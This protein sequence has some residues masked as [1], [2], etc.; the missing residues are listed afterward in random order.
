MCVSLG[1]KI[2]REYT[3]MLVIIFYSNPCHHTIVTGPP[4][5]HNGVKYGIWVIQKLNFYI[6]WCVNIMLTD[7]RVLC[8]KKMKAWPRDATYRQ[9]IQ[10]K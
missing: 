2:V 8:S 4:G 1:K 5:H 9:R 10:R 3:E 6:I 7:L